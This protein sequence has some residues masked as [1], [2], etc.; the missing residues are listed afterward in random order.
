VW[1]GRPK[2]HDHDWDV[3]VFVGIPFRQCRDCKR[4][5]RDLAWTADWREF[6]RP[7]VISRFDQPTLGADVEA[8]CRRWMDL[9]LCIAR[10]PDRA[11]GFA[12]HEA[13]RDAVLMP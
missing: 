2:P 13:R 6:L 9:W 12:A 1:R 5:E 7:E 10:A 4:V 11:R 8:E 3:R